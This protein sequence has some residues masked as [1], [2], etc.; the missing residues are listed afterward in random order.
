M[1]I[2]SNY[3]ALLSGLSWT[4]SEVT[5]TPVFVTYSFP[6]TLPDQQRSDFSKAGFRP[7]TG[8]EQKLAEKAL[9][10]WAKVS[11]IQFLKVSPEDGD[12][13]FGVYNFNKIKG[14]ST[15]SGFA[16]YPDPHNDAVEGSITPTGTSAIGGDVF[17]NRGD[18]LDFGL[19]LHEIG[20]AIGLKH[21]FETF[22]AHDAIL[23]GA[24]DTT[25]FTVMSYTVADT[26]R[27]K[28]GPLDIQAAQSIYGVASTSGRQVAS[29]S[30]NAK[31]ETLTQIGRSKSEQILGVST[32]DRIEGRSGNDTLSGLAGDDTLSGGNGHDQLFGGAGDDV[33]SGNA[34]NDSL[35][36]LTGDDL[37]LPGSG[38]NTIDGGTGNDT[39]SYADLSAAVSVVI[40]DWLQGGV[41]V[42]GDIVRDSFTG[43]ENLIG[44]AFDD[45]LSGDSSANI[46]EGGA[47]AD[48]LEGGG[49]RDTAAYATA[50][51]GVHASLEDPLANRGVAAGDSYVAIENLTGS[52]HA[53]R[54]TGDAGQNRLDGGAGKD[55]LDGR[56]GAD[57]LIGDAGADKFLFST[58]PEAGNVDRIVDFDPAT[59]RIL[60]DEAVFTA[61]STPGKLAGLQFRDLASGKVDATD[62][63]LYDTSKGVLYYD[64]DGSGS[65]TDAIRFATFADKIAL[66]AAEFFIV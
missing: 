45:A 28:L 5:G 57:T 12:I 44:S 20:H 56:A 11:G 51:T 40:D 8:E 55:V 9:A 65:T 14:M 24:L 60:L 59:D 15:S 62:R 27:V 10:A 54:L 26:G 47:G 7:L 31:A 6:E 53:D 30:W 36:G 61:F 50:T 33:L 22:G 48:R 19:Y 13:T 34:G 63:I 37:L 64:A 49:G 23:T 1:A 21:P 42:V 29:W 41:T 17:V 2:V 46:L 43:I 25:D 18:S 16:Y 4:G 35:Y 3:T 39:L 58:A 52:A 66:S 32:A 38:S